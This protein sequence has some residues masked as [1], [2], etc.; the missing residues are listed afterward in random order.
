MFHFSLACPMLLVVL[1]SSNIKEVI[2]YEDDG[3]NIH[4]QGI[5][6]VTILPNCWM[7][8]GKFKGW[9]HKELQ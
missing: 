6:A 5:C 8:G 1:R 3:T 4:C 9:S 7:G 2:I